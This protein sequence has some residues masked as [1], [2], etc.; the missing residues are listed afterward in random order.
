MADYNITYKHIK[1]PWGEEIRFSAID[2]ITGNIINEVI[3][4][5]GGR[6]DKEEILKIISNKIDLLSQSIP[7]EPDVVYTKIEVETLLKEKGYLSEEQKL[8]DLRDLKEKSTLQ[9]KK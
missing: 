9:E 5:K 8:E 6:K 2:K 7:E 3:P 1:R 4:F